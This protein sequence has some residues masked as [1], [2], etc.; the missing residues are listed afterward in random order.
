MSKKLLN[1]KEVAEAIGMSVAWM[2]SKRVYGGGIPFIKMGDN[3]RASVRYT[4]EAVEAYM[5]D[6][7]K[8]S[9]SAY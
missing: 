1:E 7:V 8:N 9:T 3:A 2:R 6:R 5:R 4:P